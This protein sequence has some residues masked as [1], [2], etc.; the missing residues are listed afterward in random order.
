V[1]TST[2]VT[3]DRKS[4]SMVELTE[5]EILNKTGKLINIPGRRQQF[6]LYQYRAKDRKSGSNR[7]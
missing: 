1:K 6:H 2:A 4:L 3:A 7:N 5:G